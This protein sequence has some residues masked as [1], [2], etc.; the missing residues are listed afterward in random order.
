LWLSLLGSLGD[1]SSCEEGH[2]WGDP[3]DVVDATLDQEDQEQIH[4]LLALLDAAQ[5]SLNHGSVT[6]EVT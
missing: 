3:K 4:L 1:S 6:I 2:S 5:I